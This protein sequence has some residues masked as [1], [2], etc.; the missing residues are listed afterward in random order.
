MKWTI[1]E[2]IIELGRNY[3]QKGRVLSAEPDYNERIWH[4]EVM[5]SKLYEVRLDGSPLEK[6]WCT[7]AYW[8]DHQYC[9]HTVAVE[10]YLKQKGISRV[11]DK[12]TTEFIA[13]RSEVFTKG[14]S[15][16]LAKPAAT[17]VPALAL[18][19]QVEMVAE[20]LF[21]PEENLFSLQ[22]KVGF[23]AN[24]KRLYVV[25]NIYDFLE[26]WFLEGNYEIN[27]EK[28]HLAR[29][30]FD[31]EINGLL[32]ELYGLA[33]TQQLGGSNA[34]LDRTRF[35]KRALLLP[36]QQGGR[37]L[38][39]MSR[40]RVLQLKLDKKITRKISFSENKR[41]LDFSVESKAGGYWLKFQTLFDY[42]LAN[43]HWGV[44]GN[45]FY[46]F[47]N[48]QEEIYLTLQQLLK[49]FKEQ[50]IAYDKSELLPLFKEVVPLLKKIGTVT[51]VEEILAELVDEP[52]ALK[53]YFH[54]EK[55]EI[56]LRIDA[57]Y[58]TAIYSTDKKHQQLPTTKKVLRDTKEEKQLAQRF[59]ALGYQ[60]T[61][62]GMAKT[63]PQGSALYQFFTQ[64]LPFFRQFGEVVLS[65]ALR[66]LFLDAQQF[67]P[68]LS[69][70]ESDSWLDIHFDISGIDDDEIDA[71]LQRLLNQENF[72]TMKNGEILSLE[73]ESFQ[74]ASQFLQQLRHRLQKDTV[75][76]KVPKYQAL[77]LKEQEQDFDI[78]IDWAPSLQ[79]L[80]LDLIHPENY[81]V[82]LPTALQAELRP[83]QLTGFR[84]LKMLSDYHLGGI[85][86]DEMGLGKTLQAITYLLAEKESTDNQLLRAVIVAPA[87]LIYNWQAELKKFAPS[88]QVCVVSGSKAERQQLLTAAADVF[89]TSYGTLRQD[90][91][92]YE[93]AQLN[94]LILDEAQ[95]VKNSAS[96][97]AQALR[98]L[99]IPK[100]FALSG[101]PIENNLGELWSLFQIIMPGFFP[102]KEKFNQ[103]STAM[104]AQ[105]IR[106]F[107]LRRAKSDVLDDLPEKIEMNI[108][109]DLTEE[110]KT[111]YLAHLRQMQEQVAGMDSN[112]FKQNRIG[113]LAGLTRLR[114]ICCHPKLFIPDYVGDSGKLEQLKEL[115]VTAKENNHKIL[116]FS[117]FTSMLTIIEEE[118]QKLGISTFY[119]RGSTNP[120]RRL[121]MVN[122]FNEGE[123]DVFLISLKA[124]GTGLNLTGAD[125]VI[126]YD[127]WW[128]PAVEEQ[129]AGRAHRIG[130][131]NVVEVWRLLAEGTVEERIDLLQN[132]KRKLFQQVIQGDE[133]QLQRLT[134]DDIRTILSI[135]AEN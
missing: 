75:E 2:K 21:R 60:E 124:G 52:L 26:M 97:T 98:D 19:C 128:N 104:V 16:I 126:L 12:P 125:T 14:F 68:Q 83:Y 129:A 110:Q 56:T 89:I 91:Q 15:R 5:G 58:G 86:A 13:S 77:F 106:P 44:I 22:L 74:Q 1:P 131:K 118:F 88:L 114:Q 108:Y 34:N 31:E 111:V 85:L 62:T 24:K 33:K 59:L 135:G 47:D 87:S 123:K 37:L 17:T 49:R 70:K 80:T 11:I 112:A 119:L 57:H 50:A 32:L 100:R 78:P 134:E 36:P 66:E 132:E 27:Q 28:V 120:K 94:Y 51:V 90:S 105:M 46:S 55:A 64:E 20:N 92:I 18:E 48:Q 113:I 76:L 107:V 10:L 43:Y 3:V 127:L 38:E 6:D 61:A 79:Q 65:K 130:Q 102:S 133:E 96:K 103:L 53:M 69:I 72:Y 40:L 4:A 71:I 67:R 95:M 30:A 109:S 99:T 41:P 7:C 101:T 81:Q 29:S 54:R 115:V 63:L 73:S 121:E 35:A 116:L 84:W 9:R 82:D 117:Q 25:K 122:A 45:H 23:L 8:Q 39:E 42:Y 93:E